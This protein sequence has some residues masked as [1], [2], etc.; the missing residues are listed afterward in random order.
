[1]KKPDRR[2]V[3]LAAAVSAPTLQKVLRGDPD[4]LPASIARVR[5]ELETL[6]LGDLLPA[7]RR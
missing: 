6:G 4:V 5:R 2:L 1:M 3:A 7:T